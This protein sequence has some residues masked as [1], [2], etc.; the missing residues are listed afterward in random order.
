MST[1]PDSIDAGD[2]DLANLLEDL[3]ERREALET[4]VESVE[5][6]ERSGLLDVLDVVATHDQKGNEQLYEAFVEDE[7]KLRLLQNLNLLAGVLSRVDPDALAG[8]LQTAST[9]D[10]LSAL[11]EG[12]PQRVGP[13][14]VYRRLRDPFVQRG[15]G[16]VFALLGAIGH[17]LEKRR[18]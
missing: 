6:L 16:F 11:A 14:G 7:G 8:L 1:K 2:E 9:S 12:A 18:P 17:L 13:I 3:A 4:L 5:A 15:L 10:E